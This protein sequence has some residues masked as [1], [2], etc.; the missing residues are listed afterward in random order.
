[1][2]ELLGLGLSH[3]GGFMFADEDMA[4]RAKA[5]LANGSLP[6]ELDSPEKW[7][8]PMQAEWGNDEGAGYAARHREQ[9]FEGLRHIREA[10]DAFK[11]DAVMIF[12]DDQYECFKEDLV[13]RSNHRIP[14]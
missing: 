13:D 2:G 11:P 1:V 9:Y 4:A 10:L 6:P 7:P 3:F 12:G 14:K 5:R 8:E